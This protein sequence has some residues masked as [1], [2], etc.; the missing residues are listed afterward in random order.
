[1]ESGKNHPC[2][3]STFNS[4]STT[5]G[6]ENKCCH[7]WTSILKHKIV[8]IMRVMRM[9]SGRG[10][11]YDQIEQW[12][13]MIVFVLRCFFQLFTFLNFRRSSLPITIAY[14]PSWPMASLS[15]S[16]KIK[17]AAITGYWR[18]AWRNNTTLL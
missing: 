16:K 2:N 15:E 4:W 7:F 17:N 12:H 5:Y 9:A 13:W 1:M 14:F 8:P 18:K 6:I 3:S 10:Q 11:E